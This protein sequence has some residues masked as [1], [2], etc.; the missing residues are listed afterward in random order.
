[1]PAPQYVLRSYG[2]GAD[3]AQLQQSI[4]ASD[5]TFAI[6]PTTGWVEE[7]G[8]PLGTVG[9]FTVVVDRFTASV[10]KILCSAVNLVTGTV[11]VYIDPDD[12][13][14]GRGYDGTN[15]QGHQP[16]GSSS[17]VQTCWS[18][19]EA[20]EANQAVFDVLGSGS[21]GLVGV[22]IGSSVPFNGTPLTIPPN[23]VLEDGSALSRSTYSALFSAITISTTGTTTAASAT[24]TAVPTGVTQYVNAGMKVTLANSGGAIYTVSSVTSTTIV[25]TSG[26]GITA[27]TAGGILVYP[28]GAGD[29][30]STFNIPDS[31]GRTKTGQSQVNT[32]AQPTQYVGQG[33]GTQSVTIAQS[34]LPTTIGTAAAQS[35]NQPN[36]DN[37]FWQGNT[38]AQAVVTLNSAST[39]A[40]PTGSSDFEPTWLQVT[41]GSTDW[42]P[43]GNITTNSSAVTNAGGG[44]ALNVESPA[45]GCTWMI[46]VH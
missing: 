36:G 35:V 27:G 16:G 33:I 28:H 25:L 40:I 18:S 22:P 23:F 1:M 44:S 37:T 31:R 14:S 3:V 24:I 9:P 15:P 45:I 2:G 6:T 26:T 8:Q 30:S 39:I 13:W 29:G 19:V 4:G 32:G 34:Q 7:D 5:I 11:N 12:G 10:E 17:G 46:R 42:N 38:S 43:T 20:A 41:F 21:S